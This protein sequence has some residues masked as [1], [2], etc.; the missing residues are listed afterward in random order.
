MQANLD[1]LAHIPPTI[2][3]LTQNI[4]LLEVFVD[5]C[6]MILQGQEIRVRHVSG[7]AETAFERAV[8]ILHRAGHFLTG[9]RRQ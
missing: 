9:W 8:E 2:T 3:V 5:A 4:L 6:K 1:C 7:E